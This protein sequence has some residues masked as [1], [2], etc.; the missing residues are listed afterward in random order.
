M[1]NYFN[2]AKDWGEMLGAIAF[3][4]GIVLALATVRPDI[5]YAV[6][7]VC[8]L[9]FGRQWHRARR[10]PKL[11]WYIIILGFVVGYTLGSV[12]YVPFVGIVVA[13]VLG[14]VGGYVVRKYVFHT[15]RY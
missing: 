6:A 2:F 9:M 11:H 15:L 3:I 1:G 8:G 14:L 10:G 4:I 7:L 5:T 13:F 12:F